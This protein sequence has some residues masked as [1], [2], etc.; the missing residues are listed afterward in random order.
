MASDKKIGTHETIKT[1]LKDLVSGAELI[2]KAYENNLEDTY[3]ETININT[4]NKLQEQR[5]LMKVFDS[6]RLNPQLNRIINNIL[7]IDRSRYIEVGL[8]RRLEPLYRISNSYIEHKKNND[9][10]LAE[11]TLKDLEQLV[12]EIIYDAQTSVRNLGNRI[13]TQ[14]G[15]VHSLKDKISE[16]ESAIKIAGSLVDNLTSF[17][18]NNMMKII[19]SSG[20]Y[21]D[22]KLY[23][24]L[25]NTLLPEL[26]KCQND[27]NSILTKLREML[28]VF[29]KQIHQTS[30]LKAFNEKFIKD[31]GYQI[32]D[33]YVN[34]IEPHYLF[35]RAASLEIKNYADLN[36]EKNIKDIEKIVSSLKANEVD[37]SVPQSTINTQAIGS[38]EP[39]KIKTCEIKFEGL[40]QELIIFFKKV[41]SNNDSI[42]AAQYHKDNK[43]EY[44]LDHWLFAVGSYYEDQTVERK[45]YFNTP[46][47]RGIYLYE[48][49]KIGNKILQ[50]IELSRNQEIFNNK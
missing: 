44:R 1:F 6:Y 37:E 21:N 2:I 20:S 16:N 19:E 24:I 8:K 43:L 29:R 22:R 46:N 38:T 27:L 13:Q 31:N 34:N 23:N 42:S 10:E 40:E 36:D 11:E 30:L 18:F 17:S 49:Q 26:A 45:K 14:F 5:I 39:P 33:Q 12:F 41:L 15:F 28:V 35:T 47:Y 4:L 7:D 50:D 32:S 25:C 9:N 3:D 48:E